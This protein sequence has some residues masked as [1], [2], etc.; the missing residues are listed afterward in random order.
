MSGRQPLYIIGN[1]DI[2]QGGEF[3]WSYLG[4]EHTKAMWKGS[5]DAILNEYGRQK[6]VS[7]IAPT[8]DTVDMSWRNGEAELVCSSVGQGEILYELLRTESRPPIWAHPK[9]QKGGEYALTANDIAM[10]RASIENGWLDDAPDTGGPYY[11]NGKGTLTY[12]GKDSPHLLL[13]NYIMSGVTEVP[14]TGWVIRTTQN[15]NLRTDHTLSQDGINTVQTPPSSVN[16]LIARVPSGVEW[17]FKGGDVTGSKLGRMQI[18]QEWWGVDNPP[19]WAAILGGS[20]DPNK[21]DEGE[22][23]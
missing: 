15:C 9:F 4:G 13:W 14:M 5:V 23:T 11:D 8:W 6:P 2:V 18:T 19:G 1:D 22:P 21:S 7:G 12:F 20:F 10:V 3:H 17:L 16:A